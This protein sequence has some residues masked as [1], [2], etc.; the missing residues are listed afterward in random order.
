MRPIGQ[1]SI[2]LVA[3]IGRERARNLDKMPERRGDAD[4]RVRRMDGREALEKLGEAKRRQRGATAQ[5][6]EFGHREGGGCKDELYAATVVVS[7]T[8]HARPKMLR[9]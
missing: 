3:L 8:I 1:Q 5:R 4:D 9:R 7:A 6:K 2:E